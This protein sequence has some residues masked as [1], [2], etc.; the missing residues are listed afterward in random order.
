VSSA[1]NNNVDARYVFPAAY[2]EVVS[3]AATDLN[4]QRASFS[5]YGSTVS[6]SAPGAFVIST[7]PGGR[8][9]A[10]WGTSFSAPLV[11]GAM[12]LVASTRGRGQ[13]DE[14]K[15]INSADSI[16]VLNPGFERKLGKGRLNV[17]QALKF[18]D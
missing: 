7:A 15:I 11:S 3:V 14:R 5:N 12:S 13:I 8:Y 4:D 18:K 10:V 17:K 2:P 9:A 6:I 16:D 1:G